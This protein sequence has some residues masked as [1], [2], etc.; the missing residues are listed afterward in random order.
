MFV[1]GH[2]ANQKNLKLIS[3][4]L[5]VPL[6]PSEK[7]L[8]N[9][10]TLKPK[11]L[12]NQVL[13]TGIKSTQDLE[14]LLEFKPRLIIQDTAHSVDF[15]LSPAL[16]EGRG[17]FLSLSTE[18][19]YKSEL[20]HYVYRTMEAR[21]HPYEDPD[22]LIIVLQEIIA[23]AIMYGNIGIESID[24]GSLEGMSALEKKLT[25]AFENPDIAQKHVTLSFNKED[26]DYLF[27][28]R[29]QGVWTATKKNKEN[30]FLRG[31]SIVEEYTSS[32][33]IDKASSRVSFSFKNIQSELL[34]R[35]KAQTEITSYNEKEGSAE[36]EEDAFSS[37]LTNV[38]IYESCLLVVD[39]LAF[40]RQIISSILKAKGFNNIHFALDGQE[41]IEKV[42]DI[43]PDLMILDLMMPKVDGYEVCRTMRQD[44][45]YRKLPI[46]I[47]TALE[48][49][50]DRN[51]AF[52]AGATDIVTK[53]INSSELTSR[54]LIH[55]ENRLFMKELTAYQA[56]L[57][58]ELEGAV[59]M[60]KEI[61]PSPEKIKD[62]ETAFNVKVSAEFQA[63][64]ELTGDMWGLI[65]DSKKRLGVYVADFSGHGVS[66]AVNT[67]RLDSLLHTLSKIDCPANLLH[68][69]SAKLKPSMRPGHYAT[70]CYGYIDQENEEFVYAASG[71]TPPLIRL[72]DQSV[73]V[74]ENAGIPIGISAD[75]T[76]TLHRA[77]FP[78]GSI[79][80]L[81]SDALSDNLCDLDD[82]TMGPLVA[83]LK[84]CTSPKETIQTLLEAMKK[85]NDVVDDDLTLLAIQ[86]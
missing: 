13:V 77:P 34:T 19:A 40:N 29:D 23:N 75:I 82:P 52:T 20:A 48:S 85:S 36:E 3:E 59:L 27:S 10:L 83:L 54:V 30:P 4:C 26:S 14:L 21:G 71:C 64:S 2:K 35:Q 33:F 6:A 8:K 67:F 15:D 61:F 12:E 17:F 55:L 38:D 73:H 32:Y 43:N 72:P 56:R 62:L 60:Q 65:K 9:A 18:T 42:R 49:S 31:T 41:A 39:D 5:G 45:E 69:L 7:G 76:Y 63:C 44:K 11:E 70:M 28:V 25:E 68:E 57:Q 84:T 22:S 86:G 47:Q 1:Y 66:A 53:P 79:L 50:I 37:F 46:I 58:E 16:L 24:R 78:K 81:Y 80:L 74:C 51:K